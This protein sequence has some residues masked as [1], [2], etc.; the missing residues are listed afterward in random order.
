MTAEDVV[1]A[2]TRALNRENQLQFTA[3]D[4]ITD[5][6]YT[7]SSEIFVDI[8]KITAMG[9]HVEPVLGDPQNSK[10]FDTISLTKHVINKSTHL[11]TKARL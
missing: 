2:I 4:Y 1:K 11:Y 9:I 10:F 5:L 8:E 6:F 3:R 7:K